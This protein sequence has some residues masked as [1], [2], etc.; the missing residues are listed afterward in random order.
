MK[1]DSNTFE[2]EEVRLIRTRFSEWQNEACML[3]YGAIVLCKGGQTDITLNFKRWSL[4]EGSVIVLY[5]NDVVILG[6]TTRDFEAE[7]L[8]FS[9]AMLREASLQLESVVYD[10]LRKDR[11]QTD[12]PIPRSLIEHMFATLALYFRQEGCTCLS[13]LVLLQLKGFFLGFYDFLLRNPSDMDMQ[14]TLTSRSAELFRMFNVLIERDYK[15]SRD[16]TYYAGKM[17][18]TPKY[19]NTVTHKATK[20][21]SKV[22]IDHYTVLQLKLLLR[23]SKRSIKEIAW[24]YNF[25]NLSFF[26]RYFKLHT[27]MTPKQYRAAGSELKGKEE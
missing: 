27:G 17:H 26:C 22:I 24:E 7:A 13:Q 10:S 5:P 16:V 3:N 18:I 21:S 15:K 14:G 12:S 23:N 20:L 11:C 19:L 2:G 9:P 6:G 4:H 25:S 1:G 8:C